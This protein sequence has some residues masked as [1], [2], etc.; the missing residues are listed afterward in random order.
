MVFQPG[1]LRPFFSAPADTLADLSVPL[2]ELWSRDGTRL[3]SRLAGGPEPVAAAA[4]AALLLDRIERALATRADR[5]SAGTTQLVG[6]VQRGLRR[7]CG[8]YAPRTHR[9]WAW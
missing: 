9:P 7:R 3:A 8:Q 1:G 2:T 5:T 6:E 4:K